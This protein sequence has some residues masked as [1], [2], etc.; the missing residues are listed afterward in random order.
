[1]FPRLGCP[2]TDTHLLLL[3]EEINRCVALDSDWPTDQALS[4]V[5]VFGRRTRCLVH[6][7][8]QIGFHFRWKRGERSP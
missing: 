7:V 3:V 1:M 2:G 5:A 8:N 6:F 4:H